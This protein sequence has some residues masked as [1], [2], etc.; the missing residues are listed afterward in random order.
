MSK[1]ILVLDIETTGFLNQGG[2]I[3]EIG[4]IKLD[5]ETGD[6]M[7]AYNSLVKEQGLDISHTQGQFG[8]I[9]KN[10]NLTYEEVL[11]AQTFESQ[12][13]LLQKLF[14]Q[15]PATAY[16]KEFDFGF[17]KNRGFQINELPCP[18]LIATPILN[19]PSEFGNGKPKWPKVEETWEYLFGKTGY[20]EA[21]RALDD[22]WHE[23]QII[24]RLYQMGHYDAFEAN[25]EIESPVSNGLLIASEPI[26]TFIM[27]KSS[28]VQSKLLFETEPAERLTPEILN[29]LIKERKEVTIQPLLLP[30]AQRGLWG[31]RN[32]N[33]QVIIPCIYE[34]VLPFS[35]G[36]AAVKFEEKWGYI[37][38]L[39]EIVLPYQFDE[40]RSFENGLAYVEI[41]VGRFSGWIDM[42]GNRYFNSSGYCVI[43][44]SYSEGT[45]IR[46]VPFHS[47]GHYDEVINI[48]GNEIIPGRDGQAEPFSCGVLLYLDYEADTYMFYN[49]LG[50]RITKK[51]YEYAES[52][53]EYLAVVSINKKFGFI[54]TFGNEVIPLIFDGVL[55]FSEGLAAVKLN[56]K[57]GFVDNSGFTRIPMIYD[58]ASSFTKGKAKVKLKVKFGFIDHYGKNIVQCIYDQA[59]YFS[60]GLALVVQNG[61]YGFI[62]TIG[63]IVIPLKYD[64][65]SPICNGR[66]YVKLNGK[67]GY[68]NRDGEE[69]IAIKYD[70]IHKNVMTYK[71]VDIGYYSARLGRKYGVL[72][73]SGSEITS[74]KYDRI[75]EYHEGF[76]LVELNGKYGYIDLNGKEIT[77]I[78]YD[79]CNYPNFKDGF[80]VIKL[81]EKTG[82]IDKLGNEY[83][84]N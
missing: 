77:P 83:W 33:G 15:Y 27:G 13:Q 74:N 16:N 6:I 2:K 63:N 70:E 9:F 32:D 25:N 8:W 79:F 31:F 24:H 76:A 39:G 22:A 56:N 71:E 49:H 84:D 7:T 20:V 3:V 78:K 5:L 69:L 44:Y 36:V 10:S 68:L 30:V 23:A 14:N 60:D 67:C 80:A 29:E 55:S 38:T 11:K 52:F 58:E 54:D 59:E 72:D 46:T 1:V 4:I 18:M 64:K 75:D 57:W 48:L 37:D 66:I 41:E 53:S 19:L 34:E 45:I 50:E 17:L 43:R 73:Y 47:V 81:G 82:K 65:A 35:Y 12:R 62:D 40:A 26:D 28:S 21:H 61:K 42:S 51:N